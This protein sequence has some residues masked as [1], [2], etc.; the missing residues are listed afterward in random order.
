MV[1]KRLQVLSKNIGAHWDLQ[2]LIGHTEISSAPINVKKS[3]CTPAWTIIVNTLFIL[4][5]FKLIIFFLSFN[6]NLWF[7]CCSIPLSKKG[8]VCKGFFMVSLSGLIKNSLWSFG[9][10]FFFFQSKNE[11]C[12]NI[13]AHRG[14]KWFS[15]EFTRIHRD[16][17][18]RTHWAH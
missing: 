3:S 17:K 5:F 6:I 8:I 12:T 16:S 14:L 18:K 2:W 13:G 10:N 9:L 7:Y 1:Q 4:W 15:K 11:H